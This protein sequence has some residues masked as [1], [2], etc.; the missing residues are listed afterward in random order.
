LFDG[1]HYTPL[2]SDTKSVQ[3]HQIILTIA[4]ALRKAES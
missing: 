1:E 4:S 3:A 2:A